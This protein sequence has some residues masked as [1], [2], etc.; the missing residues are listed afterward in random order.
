MWHPNYVTLSLPHLYAHLSVPSSCKKV[1]DVLNY[2]TPYTC[3]GQEN[4]IALLGSY[5]G[6]VVKISII[7]MGVHETNNVYPYILNQLQE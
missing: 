1:S 4:N 5:Q 2:L 6:F 3:T 7:D